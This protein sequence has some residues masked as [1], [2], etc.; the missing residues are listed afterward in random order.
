MAVKEAR[1]RAQ[2]R[3]GHVVEEGIQYRGKHQFRVQIRERGHQ[4]SQTF[5][6]LEEARRWKQ[7]T[8]RKLLGRKKVDPTL[9]ARITVA[10]VAD[11]GITVFLGEVNRSGFPGGPVS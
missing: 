5:E 6:T 8:E 4:I 11:W 2:W 7:D 3:R 1:P 10:D 9:P